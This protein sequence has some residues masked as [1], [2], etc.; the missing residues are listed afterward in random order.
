MINIL[1]IYFIILD[2][3]RVFNENV[4]PRFQFKDKFKS[5]ILS[6]KREVSTKRN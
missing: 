5:A 2:I 3:I 6:Q 1:N 4:R